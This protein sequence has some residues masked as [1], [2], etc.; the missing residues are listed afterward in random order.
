[1]K[2]TQMTVTGMHCNSCKVLIEE[3][4]TDTVGVRECSVDFA[5]GKGTVTHEETVDLMQL[6]SAIEGL[7][8]YTVTFTE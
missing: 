7:G 3:V 1:M 6:K 4:C 2:T 5:T 8:E